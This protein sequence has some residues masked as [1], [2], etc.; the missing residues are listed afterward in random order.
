VEE[1][2]SSFKTLFTEADSVRAARIIP[3]LLRVCRARISQ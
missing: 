1:H 3:A 2:L